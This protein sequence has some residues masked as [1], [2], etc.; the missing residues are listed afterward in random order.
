MIIGFCTDVCHPYN[1]DS[2][3]DYLSM[4]GLDY[5]IDSEMITREAMFPIAGFKRD[6][7]RFYY[8]ARLYFA[9][10]MISDGEPLDEFDISKDGRYFEGVHKFDKY[11]ML[12]IP[13]E[14]FDDIDIH[15]PVSREQLLAEMKKSR[16]QE[17][18]FIK[19]HEKDLYLYQRDVIDDFYEY[20]DGLLEIIPDFNMRLKVGPDTGNT[21]FVADIHSVFDVAWY[22][23]ACMIVDIK[24]TDEGVRQ[25]TKSYEPKVCIC[26]GCG[27]SFVKT[28]EQ[29]RKL[30]CG[31][32]ECERRRTSERVRRKRKNDKL[33]EQQEKAGSKRKKK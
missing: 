6:I 24:L 16:E 9:L 8:A 30:C 10:R 13:R 1:I 21:V 23:M 33:Q 27:R 11:P 12:D 29:A 2:V 14:V 4:E 7:E 26:R 28:A 22:T 20:R 18:R 32:P 5:E 31:D 17:E 25:R 15:K 3:Y 19:E